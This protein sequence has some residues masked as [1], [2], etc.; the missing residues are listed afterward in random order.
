MKLHINGTQIRPLL[1]IFFI[2]TFLRR[3]VSSFAVAALIA[4]GGACAD[5][6]GPW[7]PR[8]YY[9]IYDEAVNLYYKPPRRPEAAL[10]LM[11]RACRSNQN[12]Q[13]IL[14]YNLGVLLELQAAPPAKI[15]KAYER[16]EKIRPHALY[17]AAI[18]RIDPDPGRLES[19]YL[20]TL[21]RMTVACRDQRP[22]RALAGLRRFVAAAGSQADG[23]TVTA[24]QDVASALPPRESFAQPFFAECLAGPEHATEYAALLEELP[25]TPGDLATQLM[26]AR[27]RLDPFHSLWDVE[28]NLRGLADGAG[29]KNPATTEWHDFIRS[30]RRGQAGPAA[31]HLRAFF[32]VLDALG[33]DAMQKPLAKDDAGKAAS[34][35]SSTADLRQRNA[36]IQRR[37]TAFKRAAAV[38]I[39]GDP[40]FHRVRGNAAIQNILRP[41]LK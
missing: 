24:A 16:A 19:E 28:L 30:A 10:T 18:Q 35:A 1:S 37:V 21:S 26:R 6:D 41:I 9:D 23:A 11:E 32:D 33:R 17:R 20:Q 38:L 14:C 12:G 40:Y 31:L 13:D 8:P 2:P 25:E 36:N 3:G 39:Q 27:A 15:L 5:P 34:E 4:G 7:T 29:S 22:D